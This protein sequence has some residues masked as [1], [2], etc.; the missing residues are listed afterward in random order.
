MY[1][2]ELPLHTICQNVSYV[3]ADC[4]K[5]TAARPILSQAKCSCGNLVVGDVW[6]VH[7]DSRDRVC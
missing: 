3:K 4:A 5:L 6:D 7:R 2:L 1:H